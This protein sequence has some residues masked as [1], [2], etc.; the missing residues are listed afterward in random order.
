MFRHFVVRPVYCIKIDQANWVDVLLAVE[1]YCVLNLVA[2]IQMQMVFDTVVLPRP[3]MYSYNVVVDTNL[4]L[5]DKL[6]VVVAVGLGHWLDL[7][8]IL[9]NCSMV[10]L[11]LIDDLDFQ[12]FDLDQLNAHCYNHSDS[13][14]N[15]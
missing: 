15:Y 13:D 3:E 14:Y 10:D 5:P 7:A 8:G 1:I 2:V 6:V 9:V 12:I 4:V 11:I